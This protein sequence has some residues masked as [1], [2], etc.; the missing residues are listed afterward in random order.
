VPAA[1]EAEAL[2]LARHPFGESSLVVHAL[3]RRAGRLHLLARG[4]YRPTSG[5]FA[6]LDLFDTLALGWSPPRTGDLGRLSAASIVVRRRRLPRDLAAYRAGLGVL[7]L[8]DLVTRPGAPQPGLFELA[9]PALDRLDTGA[10]DPELEVAALGL[11][12]LA[13]LGLEPALLGCASCGREAPAAR[14]ER[15]RTAFSAAAGGRLCRACAARAR[16][17]GA[18]TGWLEARTLEAAAAALRRGAAAVPPGRSAAVRDFARRF[19]EHHLEVRPRAF[20][21][22]PAPRR[23]A[24]AAP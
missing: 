24:P 13:L 10:A 19:L 21:R 23:R 17:E 20:L 8:V 18:R 14:G 6:V 11:R 22:A 16:S 3:G 5:Y 12:T 2:L 4:A 7:E 15:D 9:A 1:R